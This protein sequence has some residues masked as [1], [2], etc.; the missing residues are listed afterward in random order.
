MT[1]FP[2]KF[3]L[4]RLLLALYSNVLTM[5]ISTCFYVYP[6]NHCVKLIV[7]HLKWDQSV[8]FPQ[9]NFQYPSVKF[10]ETGLYTE[11]LQRRGGGEQTWGI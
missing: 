7:E 6:S 4:E 11:I 1:N 8:P 2:V 9:H 5:Q 3:I 10:Q